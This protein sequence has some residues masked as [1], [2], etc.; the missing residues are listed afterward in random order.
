MND[1]Q[2]AAIIALIQS[3]FPVLMIL[4]IVS[5][6]ADQISILMLFITNGL[7]TFMLFWKRG[8]QLG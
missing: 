8:Q 6:T 3:L 4:G 1:A 2:R 5:L 7:T